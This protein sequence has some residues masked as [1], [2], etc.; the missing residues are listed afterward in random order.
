[1][2]IKWIDTSNI[3]NAFV[4]GM[5]EDWNLYCSEYNW[6][7]VSWSIGYIVGQLPSNFIL[8]CVPA[9]IWIPFLEIGWTVFTFAL[10]GAKSYK[11]LLPGR[12]ILTSSQYINGCDEVDGEGRIHTTIITFGWIVLG[13]DLQHACHFDAGVKCLGVVDR[14][15]VYDRPMKSSSCP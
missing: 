12:S 8:T 15:S 2:L 13:G 9:H 11:A 3:T 5:K 4:S 7:I 10:A 1:M 14:K 6:I